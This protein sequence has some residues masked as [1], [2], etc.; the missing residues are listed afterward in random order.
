[1]IIILILT[2][3]IIFYGVFSLWSKNYLQIKIIIYNIILNPFTTGDFE[4]AVPR[5]LAILGIFQKNDHFKETAIF[6]MKETFS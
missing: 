3:T 1:M 6:T 2:I 5:T 4:P